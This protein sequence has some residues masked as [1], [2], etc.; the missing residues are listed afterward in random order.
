MQ[1]AERALRKP[2]ELLKED[3]SRPI[4]VLA[5][6]PDSPGI[7]PVHTPRGAAAKQSEVRAG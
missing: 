1:W 6:P 7:M 3:G 4:G 2:G 5:P